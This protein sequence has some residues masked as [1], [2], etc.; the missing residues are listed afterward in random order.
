MG[1]MLLNKKASELYLNVQGH[2]FHVFPIKDSNIS[3]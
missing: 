3:E 2:F 1:P